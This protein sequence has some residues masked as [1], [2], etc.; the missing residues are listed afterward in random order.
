MTISIAKLNICISLVCHPELVSGSHLGLNQYQTELV[1]VS[2][3]LRAI[4]R[5]AQRDKISF[6]F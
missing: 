4:F 1:S 6:Y 5:R 2:G 3:I